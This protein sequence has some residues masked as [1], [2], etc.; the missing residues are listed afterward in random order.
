MTSLARKNLFNDIPRFLVAQAGIIFAVSLVTIQV[1]ILQGF[2]RSTSLLVEKSKADIWISSEDFVSLDITAPISYDRFT[3]AKQVQGVDQAEAIIFHNVLWRDASK[4]ITPATV[5]GID[6]GGQLLSPG[7]L[8]KGTLAALNQPYTL[9]TDPLNLKALNL[10]QV[11][12]Q[13]IIG[14]L[15]AKL[16]G[17]DEEIQST[18]YNPFLLASLETAKAY[19]NS[20]LGN[21]SDAVK[22]RALSSLSD[23]D[24]ITYILVNA[25]PR[26][27]L[28]D[29]K[30]KLNAALP[31]TVAYTRE[32]MIQQTQTYWVQRTSIVFILGLGAIVGI[33]VGVVIVSQILYAAVKDHLREFGTL[34]AIGVADRVTYAIVIEQ[35]LWMAVLGYIP[36]MALC[37]GLGT[38]TAAT[39]GVIIL[40]TPITGAGVFAVTVMM[41]TASAMIAIQKVTKADPAVVFKA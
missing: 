34:K 36:S 21:R 41:C 16:V 5:I 28:Q 2:I 32:E 17:L 35:A 29:L 6:P 31:N 22:S 23:T 8:E 27:D 1:G 7:R 39:K 15:E 9:I 26:Q 18:A 30:K 19:A 12:D 14:S 20:P 37:L 4:K 25:K 11:G 10:K 13:G 33:V 38:W 3:K 40:I 24:K